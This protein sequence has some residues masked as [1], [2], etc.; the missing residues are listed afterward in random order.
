MTGRQWMA[1]STIG[2][3]PRTKRSHNGRFLMKPVTIL[4]L[5]VVVAVGHFSLCYAENERAES[6]SSFE[7]LLLS[8]IQGR[9][10]Q[11]KLDFE[12]LTK[13]EEAAVATLPQILSAEDEIDRWQL[14]L[15]LLTEG[16]LIVSHPVLTELR[17]EFH[18][19]ELSQ[20]INGGRDDGAATM[21]VQYLQKKLDRAERLL[22][23]A[24]TLQEMG[25][26]TEADV[27]DAKNAVDAIN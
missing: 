15:R 13:R 4:K 2:A 11:A 16:K 1:R 6:P 24:K 10:E 18:V 14:H 26:A 9:L 5:A 23:S 3:Q 7:A 12:R 17:T 27:F 20:H 8:Y 21:V 22:G 25:R 19:P